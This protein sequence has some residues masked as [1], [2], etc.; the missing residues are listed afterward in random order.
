M[1]FLLQQ[2]VH[3]RGHQVSYS[4]K[5]LIITFQ[6][7]TNL[8]QQKQINMKMSKNANNII[9]QKKLLFISLVH[10][11][12]YKKLSQNIHF[13]IFGM[14]RQ[15]LK[16]FFI[17]FYEII[18]MQFVQRTTHRN[19]CSPRY[20]MMWLQPCYKSHNLS[21]STSSLCHTPGFL[22]HVPPALE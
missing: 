8:L 6:S 2:S 17:N 11:S 1:S 14:V 5:N 15:V 4:L 12:G 13:R 22:C 7:L 18:G 19:T 20:C 21:I 10:I 9:C 3:I 16:H